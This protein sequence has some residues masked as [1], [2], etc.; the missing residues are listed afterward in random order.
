MAMAM[1]M[2]MAVAV[3]RPERAGRGGPPRT[4]TFIEQRFFMPIVVILE[5]SRPQQWIRLEILHRKMVS[6]GPET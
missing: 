1:A 2:A 6:G 3:N 5:P 4:L